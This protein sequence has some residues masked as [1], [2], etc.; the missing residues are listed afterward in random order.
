MSYVCEKCGKIVE[1]FEKFGSGR[2]CS[3]SC[4]NGHKHSEK[5]KQNISKGMLKETICECQFCGKQFTTL[6]A[7]AS[8][9]RL[10]KLNPDKLDNPQHFSYK[11]SEDFKLKKAQ[12]KF[13]LHDMIELDITNAEMEEYLNTH[14]KCEIC[15]KTIEEAVK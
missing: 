4:A 15:G 1:D 5:T 3:R 11:H 13:K 14:Q 2:F 12:Q 6:T 10:C 7:K 9:E 8:H